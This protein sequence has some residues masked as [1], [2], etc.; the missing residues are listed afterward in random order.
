MGKNINSIC[1]QRIWRLDVGMSKA[2]DEHYNYIKEMLFE[3]GTQFVAKIKESYE[4]ADKRHMAILK[5]NK[6][7]EEVITE[8]KFSR[9]YNV[10]SKIKKIDAFFNI[11]NIK[12]L[13][14]EIN[15][16]QQFKTKYG[17]KYIKNI[18]T[19]LR[20]ICKNLKE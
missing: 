18:E 4:N 12:K 14:L 6:N 5:I 3:F 15:K 16:N 1:D 2:F 8:G 9:D 13:I 17:D 10:N 20:D 19:D 11:F 7:N